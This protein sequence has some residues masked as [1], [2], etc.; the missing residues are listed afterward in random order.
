VANNDTT[1]TIDG[2]GTGGRRLVTRASGGSAAIRELNIVH[3]WAMTRVGGGRQYKY[4]PMTGAA[5]AV[6]AASD[7]SVGDHMTLCNERQQ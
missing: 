2:N 1:T 6:K 7:K 3:W 5:M 4:Q